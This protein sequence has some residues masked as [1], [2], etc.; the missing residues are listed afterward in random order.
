MLGGPDDG[1][2]LVGIDLDTCRDP[3]NGD[4]E[5]W[6]A[7]VIERFGSYTEISPS[8]TGVKIFAYRVRLA[9]D[10]EDPGWEGRAAFKRSGGEHPPAIEV[11][12][13]GRYFAVT[14]WRLGNAELRSVPIDDFRWLVEEAG[15]R[16]VG[17][18]R[19]EGERARRIA[20]AVA[21]RLGIELRRQGKTFE[22]MVEALRADP[23]TAE[24]AEEKRR[25]Q[26][27]A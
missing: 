2:C 3:Q 20:S 11:Y 1:A 27:A 6:A 23:E 24:W 5:P 13:E 19:E 18:R 7:E 21:F 4:L 16:F 17:E 26:R 25:A 22:E 9:G 12:T 8:K 14:G 15:P 10:A